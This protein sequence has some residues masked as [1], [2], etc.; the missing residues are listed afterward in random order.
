MTSSSSF[1]VKLQ[2]QNS[3]QEALHLNF[4]GGG[5]LVLTPTHDE[6]HLRKTFYL[7]NIHQLPT[8]INAVKEVLCRFKEK[9]KALKN[10]EADLVLDH[11]IYCKA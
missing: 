9:A 10:K 1:Q 3:Q 4:V 2:N 11:A 7:P 8:K 6:E 5:N